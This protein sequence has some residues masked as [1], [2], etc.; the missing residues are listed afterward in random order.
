MV[1]EKYVLN[2]LVLPCAS[3]SKDTV[4]VC[5]IEDED[6]LS[7]LVKDSFISKDHNNGAAQ[8]NLTPETALELGNWLIRWAMMEMAAREPEVEA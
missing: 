6:G 5:D 7:L 4:M 3:Y 1:M 2:K 8:V